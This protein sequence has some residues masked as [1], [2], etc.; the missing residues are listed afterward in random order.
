[1]D[2][3]FFKYIQLLEIFAFFSGFPIVYAFIIFLKGKSKPTI[4]TTLFNLLPFAYAI[5][6]VLYTGLQL[7]K[8]Y[9]DYTLTHITEEIQ[10]PFLAIWGLLSLLFWIPVLSKKPVFSLF[11][12]LVFF[13]ILVKNFYLQLIS[14]L[15][16]N[17]FIKNFMRVYSDSIILNVGVLISLLLIYYINRFIRKKKSAPK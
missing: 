9:P 16:D 15:P 17:D 2:D 8:L 11:H 7:R 12:S 4:I 1:M 3:S 6:G 10:N 5:V 13:F 14:P